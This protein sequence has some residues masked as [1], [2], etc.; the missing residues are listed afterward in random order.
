[1]NSPG[2]RADH[3][4]AHAGY[5]PYTCP[6]VGCDAA[7]VRKRDLKPHTTKLCLGR[8]SASRR[9][10]AVDAAP[11]SETEVV[12]DDSVP[13]FEPLRC[14]WVGCQ[15]AFSG[16][17]VGAAQLAEHLFDHIPED[18]LVLSC[19]WEKCVF[20]SKTNV[21]RHLRVHLPKWFKPF[22][23]TECGEAFNVESSLTRHRKAEQIFLESK[24]KRLAEDAEEQ[25]KRLRLW[26]APDE[27]MDEIVID[28]SLFSP[29]EAFSLQLSTP[30]S[31]SSTAVSLQLTLAS[32]PPPLPAASPALSPSQPSLDEKIPVDAPEELATK[33]TPT[34]DELIIANRMLRER[35]WKAERF[36]EKVQAENEKLREVVK[37]YPQAMENETNFTP[38]NLYASNTGGGH[39]RGVEAAVLVG[40]RNGNQV[41]DEEDKDWV[42]SR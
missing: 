15:N 27:A 14:L 28:P 34:V 12:T 29:A 42:L 22:I 21:K 33:K 4:R 5:R 1:M 2:T 19:Q 25:S 7:F 9:K 31:S 16:D 35:L 6:N 40:S 11:A 3:L 39:S 23:C 20:R 38:S 41:E 36:I 10:L 32:P 18:V 17:V 37:Q 26:S 13:A 30:C 24:R 8:S